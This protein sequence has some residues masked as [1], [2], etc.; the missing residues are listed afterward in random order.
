MDC[1]EAMTARRRLWVEK[2][3]CF[4]HGPT[5]RNDEPTAPDADQAEYGRIEL[6]DSP[7]FFRKVIRKL[8]EI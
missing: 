6:A 3:D 5:D 4:P 1:Y 8:E 2:P 7:H